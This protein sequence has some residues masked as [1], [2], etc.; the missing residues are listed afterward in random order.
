MDCPCLYYKV[1]RPR[2]ILWEIGERA[3]MRALAI[4]LDTVSLIFWGRAFRV[5]NLDRLYSV[6]IL[7]KYDS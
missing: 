2:R 1:I 4:A 3:R 5:Y 6:F 7:R